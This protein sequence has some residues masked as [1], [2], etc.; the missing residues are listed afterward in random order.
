M[1][2]IQHVLLKN[3]TIVDE[4]KENNLQSQHLLRKEEK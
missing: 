4:R 3:K 2:W 1:D